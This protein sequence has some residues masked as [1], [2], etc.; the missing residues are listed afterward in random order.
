MRL[1]QGGDFSDFEWDEDKRL[2]TVGKSGID[3]LDAVAALIAPHVEIASPRS[4]EDRTKA[5]CLSSQRI[6]VVIYTTRVDRCRIISAWPAD[7]NEQ[8]TY[9]QLLGG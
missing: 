2:R 5:I 9:R 6:I 1:V 8:R 7:K 3:F 4:G